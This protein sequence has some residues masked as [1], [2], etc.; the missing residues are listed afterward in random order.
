MKEIE[1]W[2]TSLRAMDVVSGKLAADAPLVCLG[3]EDP[4]VFRRQ[5]RN[6]EPA[7]P[8]R[9]WAEGVLSPDICSLRAGT[10]PLAA[11]GFFRDI[12]LPHRPFRLAGIARIVDIGAQFRATD[13]GRSD[14]RQSRAES[15]MQAWNGAASVLTPQRWSASPILATGCSSWRG[16]VA[17]LSAS[18]WSFFPRGVRPCPR[19]AMLSNDPT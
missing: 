8:A 11:V 3:G 19:A 15:G 10:E 7:L 6:I 16:L 4:D 2:L 17:V 18:P 12:P 13:P 5:A 14:R 1:G 9:S